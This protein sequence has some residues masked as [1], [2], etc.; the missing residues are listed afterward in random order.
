M[1]SFFPLGS[2]GGGGLALLTWVLHVGDSFGHKLKLNTH[3]MPV[4]LLL[5]VPLLEGVN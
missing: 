2:N 4:N 1:M 3:S 5:L